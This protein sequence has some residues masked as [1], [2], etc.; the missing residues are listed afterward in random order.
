MLVI[1]DVSVDLL[2]RTYVATHPVQ[3]C[4]PLKAEESWLI[5]SP[6][7]VRRFKKNEGVTSFP[8]TFWTC[9]RVEVRQYSLVLDYQQR[10]T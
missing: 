1:S 2:L 3:N 8:V 7:P 10:R 4:P 5:E 6:D 9:S